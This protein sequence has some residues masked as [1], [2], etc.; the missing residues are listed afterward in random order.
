MDSQ[1]HYWL[2]E[3]SGLG[4]PLLIVVVSVVQHGS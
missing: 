1:L 2:G 3:F 4:M